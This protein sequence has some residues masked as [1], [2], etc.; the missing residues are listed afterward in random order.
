[1]IGCLAFRNMSIS[2][3]TWQTLT[4]H[5][6]ALTGYWCP[7]KKWYFVGT[8][9]RG[10]SCGPQTHGWRQNIM[11]DCVF[12][13]SII[14]CVVNRYVWKNMK[15]WSWFSWFSFVDIKEDAFLRLWGGQVREQERCFSLEL[16]CSSWEEPALR[17]NNTQFS[18]HLWFIPYTI[19][20]LFK[21]YYLNDLKSCEI[22][23]CVVCN[24]S[25]VEHF[26]F[27]VYLVKTVCWDPKP[28]SQNWFKGNSTGNSGNPM[29]A[30]MFGVVWW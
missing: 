25:F 13:H 9:C 17:K 3:F 26:K 5:C 11:L 15:N 20:L 4:K 23:L 29:L 22:P 28:K 27:T 24:P 1:M 21:T 18:S 30:Y 19:C 2:I 7:F 14:C 8:R 10:N 12:Y 16:I 6:E